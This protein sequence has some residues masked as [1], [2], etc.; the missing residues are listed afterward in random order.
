MYTNKQPDRP[1]FVLSA[2][3]FCLIEE[4]CMVPAKAALEYGDQDV[5]GQGM[6]AGVLVLYSPAAVIY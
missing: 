5:P 1:A 2:L 3:S 6:L 4:I